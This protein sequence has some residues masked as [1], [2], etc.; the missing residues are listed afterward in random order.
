MNSD[1]SIQRKRHLLKIIPHAY[2]TFLGMLLFCVLVA[3]FLYPVLFP[4]DPSAYIGVGDVAWYI[5]TN[6]YFYDIMLHEYGEFPFWNP[7]IFCGTPWAANPQVHAFYPPN[8]LRALLTFNPTPLRTLQTNVYMIALHFVLGGIAIFFLCRSHGL[9][10]AAAMV[11][12]FAFAFSYS[13]F[14]AAETNPVLL[15]NAACLALVLYT[16]RRLLASAEK[17]ERWRWAIWSGG[18]AAL[19]VLAGFPPYY[20]CLS[21]SLA[22]YCIAHIFLSDKPNGASFRSALGRRVRKSF[23]PLVVVGLLGVGLSLP[24]L[25]SSQQFASLSSRRAGSGLEIERRSPMNE[26]R[27][28]GVTLGPLFFVGRLALYVPVAGAF[29]PTGAG[30]TATLLVF[31]AFLHP[32]RKEA[33]IYVIVFYVIQ[34]CSM[35]RPFP[36]ATF[37][38]TVTPIQMSNPDY[39]GILCPVLSAVVA[40][41]GADAVRRASA[42]NRKRWLVAVA[43]SSGIVALGFVTVAAL[44]YFTSDYDPLLDTLATPRIPP[45]SFAAPALVLVLM[46][47]GCAAGRLKTL[48]LLLPAAI[49]FEAYFASRPLIPFPDNKFTYIFNQIVDLLQ[50][51]SPT[52]TIERELWQDNYRGHHGLNLNMYQLKANI[53]GYDPLHLEST[54]R[55]LEPQLAREGKGTRAL[56]PPQFSLWYNLFLYRAFWLCDSYVVGTLPEPERL[57][58]STKTVFLP[59]Q[60]DVDGIRELQASDLPE[61]SLSDAAR[62][63]F[64]FD[65]GYIAQYMREYLDGNA[66]N[67]MVPLTNTATRRSAVRFDWLS[68]VPFSAEVAFMNLDDGEAWITGEHEVMPVGGSG[69]FEIPIP[70]WPEMTVA[71]HTEPSMRDVDIRLSR[72]SLWEDPADECPFIHVVQRTANTVTLEADC[73]GPRIL[74]FTDALYPGWEAT[75]DGVAAEIFRANNAF[76]AVIL[77]EGRHRV[78]FSFRPRRIYAGLTGAALALSFACAGL[79]LIH[80]RQRQEKVAEREQIPAQPAESRTGSR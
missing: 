66:I 40:G 15:F 8:V 68:D 7:L 63:V 77:A 41:F 75:V 34:D 19:L 37:L 26:L 67:V 65:E 71:L 9:S 30:L 23:L 48:A 6:Q 28:E 27:E 39:T 53:A 20:A 64:V 45:L 13:M 11:A 5:G 2:L 3:V 70:A 44:P 32:K 35:G 78:H 4:D 36:V 51:D 52:P 33:L 12:T 16:L 49:A 76:K 62:E 50:A 1:G 42:G 22:V 38:E 29:R 69:G 31:L 74:L 18:A 56:G 80:R 59:E 10:R 60:V 46:I 73:Q 54:V 47:V 55:V 17:W 57:F 14:Q 24:L 25:L 79:L 43:V 61:S 72:I 21:F 58:P